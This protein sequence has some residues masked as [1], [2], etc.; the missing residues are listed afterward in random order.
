MSKEWIFASLIKK[1]LTVV[2]VI[3]KKDHW[4]QKLGC[5]K[6][7]SKWMEKEK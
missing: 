5:N 4:D 1:E 3:M 7:G 2:S 6:G